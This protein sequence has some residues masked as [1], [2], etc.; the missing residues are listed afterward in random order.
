MIFYCLFQMVLR[1]AWEGGGV[2]TYFD[3]V[4]VYA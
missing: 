3:A 4:K 1:A 2:L